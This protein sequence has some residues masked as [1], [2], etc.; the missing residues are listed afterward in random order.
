M[1][2]TRPAQQ[3]ARLCAALAHA[4]FDPVPLPLLEIVPIAAADARAPA[5]RQRVLMLDQYQHVIFISANAVSCG[6]EWLTAYWPQW[7]QELHWYAI[8]RATAEQLEGYGVHAVAGHEAMNSEELLAHARLRDVSAARI[9]IVR[10]VGGRETLAHTLRER[11]AQVDYCEVYERHAAQPPPA[12]LQAFLARASRALCV[13]SS[14][15]LQALLALG[16]RAQQLPAL[17]DTLLIAPGERVAQLARQH[18][19]RH[20]VV[21]RNAGIDATIDALKGID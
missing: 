1:L 9:L 15:T 11:G 12:T 14:E 20:I 10:G 18:G 13:S 16:E 3:Q 7:P 19:F 5:I 8:G 21:A 17:L 4:G 2:V 6:M